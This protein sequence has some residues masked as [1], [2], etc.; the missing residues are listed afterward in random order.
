VLGLVS[1]FGVALVLLGTF[2][3]ALGYGSISQC[4]SLISYA[5]CWDLFH[6]PYRSGYDFQT[7]DIEFYIGTLLAIMGTVMLAGST[8]ARS[9]RK[10]R[11]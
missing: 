8:V 7:G 6:V 11:G 2:F 5:N 4:I 3:L 9:L 10:L 1:S